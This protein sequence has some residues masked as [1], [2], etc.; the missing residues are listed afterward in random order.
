MWHGIPGAL[1]HAAIPLS[2]RVNAC[3]SVSAGSGASG[4]LCISSTRSF[5]A[6]DTLSI[7]FPPGPYC[8]FKTICYQ[9]I[10]TVI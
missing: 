9:H 7:L 10:T 5:T 4:I 2:S 3:L 8:M 6:C 1:R